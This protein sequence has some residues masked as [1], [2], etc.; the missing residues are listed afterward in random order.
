MRTRW[1][2]KPKLGAESFARYELGRYNLGKF[3]SPYWDFE[4]GL[5][6]RRRFEAGL[7]SYSSCLLGIN[8]VRLFATHIDGL[9]IRMCCRLIVSAYVGAL[10]NMGGIIALAQR[11][12]K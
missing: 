10:S 3:L 2:C 6:S 4:D 9:L 5:V 11:P 7:D 8:W 12:V 1:S